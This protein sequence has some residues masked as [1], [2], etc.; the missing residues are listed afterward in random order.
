MA[1]SCAGTT[2]PEND[3]S[4]K[5]MNPIEQSVILLDGLLDMESFRAYGAG[6]PV[7]RP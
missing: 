6:L 2:R 3:S 1:A 7:R 4:I 5:I